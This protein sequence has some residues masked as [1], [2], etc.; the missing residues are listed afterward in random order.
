M[1]YTPPANDP[2]DASRREELQVRQTAQRIL[3]DHL[4][5]QTYRGQRADGSVPKTFWPGIELLDLTGA[6]LVDFHLIDCR[7]GS[8]DFNR[9]TFSG[10]TLFRGTTC[11]LGFFQGSTFSHHTDFR[12]AVFTNSAWF[13]YSTFGTEVWFHGDEFYP[14]ASFG[15]HADF[16]DVTFTRGA[17]FS[18]A[19]F[20]G[21]AD[22]RGA[23]YERGAE[24]VRLE[25]AH[26]REPSAVSPEVSN[27]ASNW[28]PGWVVVP[29]PEGAGTPVW[30]A[31]P[32]PDPTG[33]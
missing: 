15:R 31:A 21:S 8:T 27:A 14:G 9:V 12:G 2:E 29:G 26:V 4:R 5:D 10:E 18:Q 3:A 20:S 30:S 28:P 7:I 16:Q 22:F 13:S 19:T 6:H 24:T 32:S 33:S 11:D 1:P 25:G 17:R 23:R